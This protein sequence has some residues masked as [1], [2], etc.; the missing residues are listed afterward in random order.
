MSGMAA[1][2]MLLEAGGVSSNSVTDVGPRGHRGG[3]R[4]SAAVVPLGTSLV[5]TASVVAP[6]WVAGRTEPDSI[7]FVG[8]IK[9]YGLSVLAAW[10]TV[11]YCSWQG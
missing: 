11:D 1:Q 7:S 4:C 2:N 9:F 5:V 6:L 3:V 8:G 10:A